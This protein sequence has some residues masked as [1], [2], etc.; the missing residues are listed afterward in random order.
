MVDGPVASICVYFKYKV[1]LKLK[2]S[3]LQQLKVIFIIIN[4]PF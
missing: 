4:Q 2:I 1:N 3:G